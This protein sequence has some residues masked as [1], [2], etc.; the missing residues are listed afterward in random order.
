[1][2]SPQFA[3]ALPH[4][5][6]TGSAADL[7]GEQIYRKRCASCHGVN[8]E[9]ATKKY[10]KPL[11][12][13]K[14]ALQLAKL[15]AK[16]MPEDDPGT[17]TGPEAE[18]VAAYIYDAF[19]SVAARERNK[20]PRIELARLTVKQYR[21]AVADLIGTFRPTARLDNRHGLRGEY[22]AARGF[23][24]N[25]RV[26]DRIDPE[27]H[28]D[29]GT[30]TPAVGSFKPYEFTIRWEGSVQAPETGE[31][32]FIVHTEHALRLWVNDNR[33]AL[34][35]R[36]VKSGNDTEYRGSLF[37]IAGRSYPLRLEFSKSQ[38]GVNDPEARQG[39]C[40]AAREHWTL[41]EAAGPNPRDHR[42][43]LFVARKRSS[44]VC[45]GDAVSA[46]RSQHGLGTRHDDLEGV[47]SG[48]DRRGN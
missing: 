35:D 37:L 16:T 47:G 12:G 4:S 21:N 29:F 17:C 13:D 28:F 20:P 5:S 27:V 39:A 9:G 22:F 32:E 2:R 19:Y 41:M 26:I 11:A 7:T 33:N 24:R 18:K 40:A 8:G 15:I 42:L 14:D 45:G 43:A 1:M 25:K 30:G 46:G 3:S 48:N 34:I 31:Y 23:Q 44:F 36:W 10:K 6:R 38:Q